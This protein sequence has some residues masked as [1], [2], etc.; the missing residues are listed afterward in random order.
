MQAGYIPLL[1]KSFL[2]KPY[3]SKICL[4]AAVRVQDEATPKQ[5]QTSPGGR[6]VE[7]RSATMPPSVVGKTCYCGEASPLVGI[8]TQRLTS[9]SSYCSDCD[10]VFTPVLLTPATPPVTSP[11]SPSYSVFESTP[12]RVTSLQSPQRG[13]F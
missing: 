6:H 3:G 2:M 7:E 5:Q 1:V 12:K 4:G 13:I 11:T 10:G 9:I 8:S